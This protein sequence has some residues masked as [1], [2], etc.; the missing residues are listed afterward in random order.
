[1]N[2]REIAKYAALVATEVLTEDMLSEELGDGSIVNEIIAAA[3]ATAIVGAASDTIENA[4]D[5]AFD[6]I[7]DF[8]PFN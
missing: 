8:N 4:V 1:M 7:D 5:S 2:E 6:V 3:G